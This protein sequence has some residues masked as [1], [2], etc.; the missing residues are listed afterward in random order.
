MKTGTIILLVGLGY[1]WLNDLFLYLEIKRY[2]KSKTGKILYAIHS[3][4]FIIGLLSYHFIIPRIKSPEAFLVWKRDRC[5]ILM[6]CPQN[7]LYR[8]EWYRLNGQTTETVIRHNP[9]F[10]F[11]IECLGF[12]RYFLWNNV[13]K[14]RL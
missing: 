12:L 6:L 10:R 11:R 7:N 8:I 13:G 2:L 5:F 4:L 1:I 14:I 3:L 9:L